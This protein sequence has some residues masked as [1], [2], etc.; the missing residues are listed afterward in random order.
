MS[1]NIETGTRVINLN[2]TEPRHGES[3][4]DALKRIAYPRCRKPLIC[5]AYGCV[6]HADVGGHVR[7]ADESR[8][9]FI[10][11]L[12]KHH[13]SQ[14]YKNLEYTLKKTRAIRAVQSLLP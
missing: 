14:A 5:S 12:C 7:L 1:I 9:E 6:L 13:N 8:Q 2:G 11:A 4:L 3:W 10:V